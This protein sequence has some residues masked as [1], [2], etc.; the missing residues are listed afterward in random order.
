VRSAT[1]SR[2]LV[3]HGLE[4][5]GITPLAQARSAGAQL[6]FQRKPVYL[7]L[8]NTGYLFYIYTS[9]FK[10]EAVVSYKEI[11]IS[12]YS[13]LILSIEN[14]C[15]YLTSLLLYSGPQILGLA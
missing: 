14:F 15:K 4:G 9:N 11:H 7:F 2:T 13:H 10:S 1:K 3:I 12:L 6:I 5:W 8:T